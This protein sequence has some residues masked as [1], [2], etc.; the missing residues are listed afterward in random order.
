MRILPKVSSLV[1]LLFFAGCSSQPQTTPPVVTVV[2]NSC[3]A[4]KQLSWSVDDT[5]ES[6][7][8]IR[9]HNAIHAKLCSKKGQ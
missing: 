1:G 2:D 4:F 7:T 9:R 6:A 3:K 5:P 8:G